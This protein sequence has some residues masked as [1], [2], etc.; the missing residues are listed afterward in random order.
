MDARVVFTHTLFFTN[1][2]TQE[3]QLSALET[4]ALLAR[5]IEDQIAV[6]ELPQGG[7]RRWDPAR[8]RE[9]SEDAIVRAFGRRP[10][11]RDLDLAFHGTPDGTFSAFG[12]SVTAAPPLVEGDADRIFW[13][14]RAR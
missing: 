14:P 4:L 2:A 1:G 3:G 7:L 9:E 12:G 5:D 13:K 10:D 6:M 11:Q 8:F